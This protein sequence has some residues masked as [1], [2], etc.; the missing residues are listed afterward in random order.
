MSDVY[1]RIFVQ[2]LISQFLTTEKQDIKLIHRFYPT[3]SYN[4]R[5]SMC[6]LQDDSKQEIS[7]GN[8]WLG[9]NHSKKSKPRSSLLIWHQFSACFR[10]AFSLILRR[11]NTSYPKKTP[12]LVMLILISR[13]KWYSNYDTNYL[14]RSQYLQSISWELVK[15]N[16]ACI[17]PAP[18]LLDVH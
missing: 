14:Q 2:F 16:H 4:A 5:S 7:P 6:S 17:L 12:L 9:V 3:Y 15:H 11:N 13:K 1:F 8:F 10:G 18:M